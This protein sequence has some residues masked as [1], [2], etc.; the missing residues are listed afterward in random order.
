MTINAWPALFKNTLQL[1]R[2]ILVP[3]ASFI[4]HDLVSEPI[5]IIVGPVSD[6]TNHT[7]QNVRIHVVL[8]ISHTNCPKQ[9][10]V[11]L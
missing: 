1:I 2:K 4:L 5:K 6:G 8:A 7:L 9:R 3:N 11:T 10:S